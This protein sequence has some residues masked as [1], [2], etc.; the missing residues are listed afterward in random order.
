MSDECQ[1]CFW[2]EEGFPLPDKWHVNPL[3]RTFAALFAANPSAFQFHSSSNSIPDLSI[4]IIKNYTVNGS[5]VQ[6]VSLP[7]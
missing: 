6:P 7:G 1:F 3:A 4:S 2:R 5:V